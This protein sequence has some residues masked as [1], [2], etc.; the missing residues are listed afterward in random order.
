M[1]GL[2]EAHRRFSLHYCLIVRDNTRN[3]QLLDSEFGQIQNA[4]HWLGEQDGAE[5]ARL[6]IALVE[7]LGQYLQRR[8]LPRTLLA[9]CQNGLLAAQKLGA[10][11]GPLLLLTF[12]AYW[13]IGE[14]GKALTSVQ[15]AIEATQGAEAKTYAQAILALGRLQL[16]RGEYGLAL[17]TLSSAERLL[18]EL[19]DEEGLAT[20]KA[21]IAAYHLN[22]NELRKALSLYL[23]ADR[24]RRKVEPFAPSDH[25][26][27]MLGVVYRRR[28]D[29]ERAAQYLSELIERGKAQNNRAATATATHHLAWVYFEQRKLARARELGEQAKDLYEE[30]GDP[31]GSSDADEQL[32]L[33]A[34]AEQ[35][36]EAAKLYLERSLQIRQ[37]LGN[38]QGAASSLRRLAKLNLRQRNWGAGLHFLWES[39]TLYSRLGALSYQRVFSIVQDLIR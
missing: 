8:T 12:E 30:F 16:N 13:A 14:W 29:Y 38:Q 33:I 9:F 1:P 7:D 2:K 19:S 39:I 23:E 15:S 35:D 32:G 6:L 26:L 5:T 24:L 20:A 28:Q 3:F 18:T 10:N 4:Y 17:Q 21:E 27:L 36:F 37:Q 34:L 11:P 22:R 31:R 25:T